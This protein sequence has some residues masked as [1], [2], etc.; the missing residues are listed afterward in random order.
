MEDEVTPRAVIITLSIIAAVCAAVILFANTTWISVDSSHATIVYN[1]GLL[2]SRGYDQTVRPGSGK[3][4]VGLHQSSF[5]V[6]IGYRQY[7]ISNDPG[8]GADYVGTVPVS[9]SGIQMG[10]EPTILFTISTAPDGH[11]K[12]AAADF[13]EKHL[14]QFGATDFDVHGAQTRWV[15]FLNTRVYPV[16]KSVMQ[17]QLTGENPV[18]LRFNT[19]GARD[20]AADQLGRAIS[21]EI[22][23]Q[24]GGRYLCAVGYKYGAPADTCGD[25]SVQLSEPEV[26]PAVK[27]ALEAPQRAKVEADNAVAAAKEKTRQASGEAAERAAQVG[28]AAQKA[29]ADQAIAASQLQQKTADASNDLAPCRALGVTDGTKCALLIAALHDKFPTALGGDITSAAP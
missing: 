27:D 17:T 24:L 26:D 20:Q 3:T 7:R 6:P 15:E 4:L 28:S 13:Y 16:V 29:A 14:R 18:A 11:G 10:W 2:D 22:E 25:V 12:P 19:D 8:S 1:G 23:H 5:E 21:N 9:V